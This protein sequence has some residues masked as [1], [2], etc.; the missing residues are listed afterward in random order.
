MRKRTKTNPATLQSEIR[1]VLVLLALALAGPVADPGALAA[2]DVRFTGNVTFSA[3]EDDGDGLFEVIIAEAE[4]EV[5]TAGEYT[6]FGVLEKDGEVISYRPAFESALFSSATLSKPPGVYAVSLT[7]SGEEV[8]QSGEDGPYNLR[9]DAIGASSTTRLAIPTPAYDHTQFGELG[10]IIAGATSAAVDEDGD[11]KFDFVGVTVDVTV[12]AAGVFWHQAALGKHGSTIAHAGDRF[13]LT[14]GTHT[15][16]LRLPGLPILRSGLNGPYEGSVSVIDGDGHTLGSI[17]FV[18]PAYKSAAF[19]AFLELDGRFRDRGID[20]NYNGLF[21]IWRVDVGARV[22]EA[23][24]F[25]VGGALKNPDEPLVVFTDAEMTLTGAAQMI[26]LEFRGPLI[27]EQEIDGPYEVEVVLREPGTYDELDRLRLGQTTADYRS[28]D[29]EPFDWAEIMPTGVTAD[30]GVD[31]DGN[32]VF[33]ELRVEIHVELAKTDFYQWSARLVDQNGT[34]IDVD[35]RNATLNAGVATIDLVF[36]GKK[37]GRNGVDGPYFVKGL[38]MYGRT[39]PNLVLLDVAETQA[40]A[41]TDFES[42]ER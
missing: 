20:T 40:Y 11:G 36:D 22:E 18:T 41:V 2:Q 27:R 31:T 17:G 10:A 39:G 9:L 16:N 26:T 12:R 13:S 28:T 33:D 37:I 3:A 34:D 7:F 15:S 30:E 6:I 21:D 29:F 5:L 24:T 14:P 8:F 35:S 4:V 23:G 19:A 25:L 42:G 32:G 1:P 38:G